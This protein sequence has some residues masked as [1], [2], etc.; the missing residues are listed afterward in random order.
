MGRS[1]I[2]LYD[3]LG[4][5]YGRDGL[6]SRYPSD[7]NLE[8]LIIFFLVGTAVGW[9]VKRAVQ[10]FKARQNGGCAGGCNC[11]TKVRPPRS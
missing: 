10:S 7:M 1:F 3:L 5:G 4:L 6:S 11:S 2:F 8:S 9:L